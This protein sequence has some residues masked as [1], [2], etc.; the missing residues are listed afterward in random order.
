MLIIK[1]MKCQLKVKP[2]HLF[3]HELHEVPTHACAHAYTHT[4]TWTQ[5]K[6]LMVKIYHIIKSRKCL[7]LQI[8]TYFPSRVSGWGF[9]QNFK[10]WFS[11]QPRS[12]H[13]LL[14][15]NNLI[16][17]EMKRR[18]VYKRK[19]FSFLS[20]KKV[21]YEE[22]KKERKKERKNLLWNRL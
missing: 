7:Q 17:T 15:G 12:S 9:S 16:G 14:W 21:V 4:H 3:T 1:T 11:K 20:T 8:N 10:R 13:K 5:K 6:V 22:R 18:S 2:V 19:N